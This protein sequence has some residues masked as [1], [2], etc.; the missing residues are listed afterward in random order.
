MA[1]HYM[2]GQQLSLQ[3]V[4]YFGE[5]SWR[6]MIARGSDFVSPSLSCHD[7]VNIQYT[8]GTTGWP[9]AYF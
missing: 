1:A 9:K 3:H 6:E 2:P 4:I 5:D 7:V 8:S